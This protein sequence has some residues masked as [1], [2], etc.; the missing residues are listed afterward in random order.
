MRKAW[1]KATVAGALVTM[2]LLTAIIASNEESAAQTPT[3]VGVDADPTGNTATSLGPIESCVSVATGDTFEVDVFVMDVVDLLAWETTFVYD[4]AIISIVDHDLQMF[5][6]ANPGSNVLDISENLPDTDGQY[7]LSGAD[8]GDPLSPDSGSGVLASLTLKAIG[9]GVSPAR[10]ASIDVDGD[11]TADL[12]TFLT[13]VRND[14]I[15]DSDDDGVFDGPLFD[16]E[17]A[18]DTACPPDTVVITP[19]PGSAS[20]SPNA[21][22]SPTVTAEPTSVVRPTPAATPPNENEE[23]STW[24]SDPWIAAYVVGGIAVLLVAAALFAVVRRRIR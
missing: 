14:P 24:T 3:V 16:A 18:V 10:L 22:V 12:A 8:I 19:R 4:D 13:D 5:Q 7:R 17:I 9:P 23:G 2:A 21:S 11:G 6:A 15:S 20:P 1:Q